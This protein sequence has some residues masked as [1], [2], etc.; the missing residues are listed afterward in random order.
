MAP[1]ALVPQVAQCPRCATE[2]PPNAKTCPSCLH[3]IDGDKEVY[4][5]AADTDLTNTSWLG[6][7]A[8]YSLEEAAKCPQ[9]RESIDSVRV[10]GLTR[11]QVAFTSTLPRKGRVIV[12]PKCSQILSAELSGMV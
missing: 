9:C 6:G 12:C 3:D 8:V 2:L 4:E 10:L 11:T 1:L 7:G 5:I